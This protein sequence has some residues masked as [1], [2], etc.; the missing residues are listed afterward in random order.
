MK[1]SLFPLPSSLFHLPSSLLLLTSLLLTTSCEKMF[2]PDD[3][4]SNPVD[5]FEYLWHQ[6]DEHYSLFDVKEVDWQKVH[7]KQK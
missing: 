3:V 7:E 2:M 4:S 6:V 5:V 1:K